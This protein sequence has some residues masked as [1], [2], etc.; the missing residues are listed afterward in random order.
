MALVSSISG[1]I[2]LEELKKA[3]MCG[4]NDLKKWRSLVVSKPVF[5]NEKIGNQRNKG[6]LFCISFKNGY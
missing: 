3:E 4:K 6:D 2:C 1:F 5:G